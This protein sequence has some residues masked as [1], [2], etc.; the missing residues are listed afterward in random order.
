MDVS[1]LRTSHKIFL[2]S[3]SPQP[4]R[5]P[6]YFSAAFKASIIVDL[7]IGPQLYH[8]YI[9]LE[10]FL[11]SSFFWD[12]TVH[13]SKTVSTMNKIFFFSF[14]LEITSILAQR[15]KST[16]YPAMESS[17][18]QQLLVSYQTCSTDIFSS[19]GKWNDCEWSCSNICGGATEPG[20]YMVHTDHEITSL[21]NLCMFLKKIDLPCVRD[22]LS[23]VLFL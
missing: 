10:F 4:C 5:P 1:R 8:K 20:S 21:L 6:T 14:F 16:H 13:I 17:E 7:P 18:K 3:P 15:K 19:G 11:S 22:L 23:W 12:R 2:P 9:Y